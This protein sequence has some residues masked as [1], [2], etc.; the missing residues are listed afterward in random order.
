MSKY[1][2]FILLFLLATFLWISVIFW[3]VGDAAGFVGFFAA[4]LTIVVVIYGYNNTEEK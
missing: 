3:L 2:V 1:Y 4:V